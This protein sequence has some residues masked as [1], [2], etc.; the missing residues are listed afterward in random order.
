MLAP[1]PLDE[2]ELPVLVVEVLLSSLEQA[3]A[4]TTRA[5]KL[6]STNVFRVLRM[7]A[8]YGAGVTPLVGLGEREVNEIRTFASTSTSCGYESRREASSGVNHSSTSTSG[9]GTKG[10]SPIGCISQ[11]RTVFVRP[12]RSRY[13]VGSS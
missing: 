12:W 11:Y 6:P 2:L 13:W 9:L 7:A 3:A 8:T 10:R 1:A 5:S 4:M